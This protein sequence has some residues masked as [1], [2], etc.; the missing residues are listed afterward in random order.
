MNTKVSLKSAF[1]IFTIFFS[2]LHCSSHTD[3]YQHASSVIQTCTSTYD[4]HSHGRY[5]LKTYIIIQTHFALKT[6][7][8]SLT[9]YLRLCCYYGRVCRCRRCRSVSDYARKNLSIALLLLLTI[10]LLYLLPCLWLWPLL[11]DCNLCWS[12]QTQFFAY[13]LYLY[14]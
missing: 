6:S 11:F 2:F 3:P 12:G 8:S 7:S 13:L 10:A 1:S 5:W 14:F 4:R 9:L